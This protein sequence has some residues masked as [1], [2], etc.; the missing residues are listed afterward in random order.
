MAKTTSPKYSLWLVASLAILIA[1][2]ALY[3]N[4]QLSQTI[5][6]S[7]HAFD[8][9]LT[10]LTEQQSNTEARLQS[11][12]TTT[13]TD[14]TTWQSKINTLENTLQATLKEY[15]NLSDDWRLLKARHLLEL[16]ALNAHWSTNKDATIA[17]LREAD[18]FLAPIHNPKLLPVREGLAHDITEQLN[19][20]TTDVTS[21]LTRLDA[22]QAKTWDLPIKPL[23]IEVFSKHTPEENTSTTQPSRMDSALTFLKSLVVI[24]YN[25]DT[26]EPKPTLAY[27]AM[28]RATVRLNLQEAQWAIL[29]QNN[30]IYHLALNQAIHHLE[31]TF[32]SNTTRTQALMQQLEQLKK[33]NLRTER[34]IPEEA[35]N[36]LNPIINTPRTAPP[37]T[38]GAEAS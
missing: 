1:L 14:Q 23:P 18:V 13:Q 24:H 35:L 37:S 19:A 30:T 31:H 6:R 22:I 27:E 2:S 36:Q 10:M 8:A 38:E 20:P 32:S 11:H 25:P 9:T 21:L 4:W 34:V 29:E 7:T 3:M 33:T 26:L 17:M 28:L 5:K 15:T 12:R 16:A